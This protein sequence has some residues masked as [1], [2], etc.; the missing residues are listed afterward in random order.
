MKLINTFLAMSALAACGGVV[1]LPVV[2]DN[3]NMFLHLMGLCRYEGLA[4]GV[5]TVARM[6]EM[7]ERHTGLF[8]QSYRVHWIY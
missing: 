6:E 8:R 3:E 4:F 7:A 2:Q 1:D 5:P